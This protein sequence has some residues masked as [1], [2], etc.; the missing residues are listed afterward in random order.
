MIRLR[1]ISILV[2]EDF[3]KVLD[4]IANKLHIK[5]SDIKEYKL[6]KK[7]IDAR[8]KPDVYYSYTI[9]IL[10]D[11]EKKLL[12]KYSD[13]NISLSPVEK[14]EYSPTGKEKY[15]KIVVVG[16]GPAGLLCSYMLCKY[17]YN[18]LVIERGKDVDSRTKDIENFWNTGVLLENSNVSFGE[19]GAGTFSDGKL[20]TLVSDK[21]F[22]QK[23][24]FKIFVECGAPEEIMYDAK[25]H[26]GTDILKKVVKNLRNK[27]IEF[28]GEF[29]FETCLTNLIIEN[30]TIKQIEVNNNEL[31]DADIVVL[32]IGHSARDTF[33]MLNDNKIEMINK[34][35]AIGVRVMHHQKMINESQYGSKYAGY[36]GPASYKL[37]YNTKD[38]RGVYSFCMCPGGYVV[39]ASSMKNHLVVN[40]MS[41][42]ARES[43]NA[44]SAIIV[45]VNSNDFG[46]D[47][48]SGMKFQE[49]LEQ[50]AYQNCNGNIPVQLYKDLKSNIVSNN[51]ESVIPE[52][53][54]KYSFGNI[55][56]II[57]NYVINS[58]IEGMEYFGTKIKGYNNDDTV[59]AGI[60]TRTSSP[61]RIIRD[62]K[63]ESNIKGIY[64][65]GE[66]AGYAG[67]IT[68]AAIDGI[69]VFEK[70]TEVYQK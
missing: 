4:K 61:I 46:S 10:V 67:G 11:N 55:N 29:R 54:G 63:F 2:D 24:I 66:G 56:E 62:D 9:D 3:T 41:N 38:K 6:I 19:G 49:K 53:K 36:L 42:Y 17:G 32:A 60:E 18:V 25:P 16:S 23:E 21:Y 58:L 44:N 33:L 15:N 57:P 1:E 34:P 47:L 14:Y 35:F 26:I 39:N 68:S 69:K 43:S 22:R 31:I 65:C 30:N 48:F 52:I 5:K 50:I 37:T 59:I 7:S 13:R 45:T 27:I 64:P 51:F 40:G 20:N 70:I 8:K 12:E 28:G